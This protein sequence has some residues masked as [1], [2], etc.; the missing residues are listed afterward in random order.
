MRVV[1]W[2]W[3]DGMSSQV[4]VQVQSERTREGVEGL[5][6]TAALERHQAD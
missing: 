1:R 4:Q 2:E 5:C 3:F 6:G